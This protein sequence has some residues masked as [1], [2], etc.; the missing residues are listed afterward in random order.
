MRRL[1]R[2]LKAFLA[3]Y[4]VY[5]VVIEIFLAVVGRMTG[6]YPETLSPF[7]GHLQRLFWCSLL[8]GDSFLCSTNANFLAS[9]PG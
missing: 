1:G 8:S 3:G 7:L 4:V 6:G 9:L 2:V 5:L